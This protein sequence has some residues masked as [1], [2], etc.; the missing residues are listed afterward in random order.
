MVLHTPLVDALILVAFFVAFLAPGV[1]LF[2]K[3]D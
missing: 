3:Q 1:A 2:K